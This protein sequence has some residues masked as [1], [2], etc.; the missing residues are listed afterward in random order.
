MQTS[1]LNLKTDTDL[2]SSKW[3]QIQIGA[4]GY[5]TRTEEIT[6]F[7]T[8]RS[9]SLV[10]KLRNFLMTLLRLSQQDTKKPVVSEKKG[11]G[12]KRNPPKRGSN[13]FQHVP[14]LNF[15][16]RLQNNLSTNMSGWTDPLSKTYTYLKTCT[17][18]NVSR[19]G[20]AGSTSF[21]L[22]TPQKDQ[23]K[24][25]L[26]SASTV[27]TAPEWSGWWR[28]NLS[29]AVMMPTS[30]LSALFIF[31]QVWVFLFFCFPSSP[32]LSL[33]WTAVGMGDR[34]GGEFQGV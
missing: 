15:P 24:F 23:W 1:G 5:T 29:I 34:E 16:L 8:P 4:V 3:I 21:H 31:P 33:V 13:V 2:W 20:T 6:Q 7:V 19:G 17:I 14:Q 28:V 26:R 18:I 10:L 32:P 30:A 9:S 12:R 27:C 11:G 22:H 25:R